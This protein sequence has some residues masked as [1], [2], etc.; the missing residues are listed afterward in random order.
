[1]YKLEAAMAEGIRHGSWVVGSGGVGDD[2]GT[3]IREYNIF[4]SE[5]LRELARSFAERR[6][7][8]L[9]SFFRT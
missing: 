1:M 9:R 5:S 4:E 8:I 3:D 2:V 7:E 6:G